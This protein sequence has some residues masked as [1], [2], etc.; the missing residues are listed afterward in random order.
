M[1]AIKNMLNLPKEVGIFEQL[2]HYCERGRPKWQLSD[3]DEK[4]A[5]YAEAARH[6][7]NSLEVEP[8]VADHDYWLFQSKTK[9]YYSL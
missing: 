4:E 5:I 7:V 9:S 6:I 2:R 3:S 1:M 8:A